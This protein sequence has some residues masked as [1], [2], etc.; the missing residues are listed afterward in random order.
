V[1]FDRT[2]YLLG[3]KKQQICLAKGAGDGSYSTLL[4]MWGKRLP[5]FWCL[6]EQT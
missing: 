5:F 3:C 1:I 2:L 6:K 4:P